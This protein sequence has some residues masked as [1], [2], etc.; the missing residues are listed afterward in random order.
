[1]AFD[2]YVNA[3]AVTCRAVT[4]D[5]SAEHIERPVIQINAAAVTICA[6]TADRSAIHI[7]RSVIQINTC[8]CSLNFSIRSAIVQT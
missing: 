2:R 7:E 1:M 3:A 4:A 8:T 6:I 5:R